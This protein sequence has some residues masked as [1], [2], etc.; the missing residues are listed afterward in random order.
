MGFLYLV[1]VTNLAAAETSRPFRF[2]VFTTDNGLP[3][4]SVRGITQTPDGYLWFTT[5]DG[6]VRFDGVKFTVFDKSNTP[7]IGSNRFML[8]ESAPDGT[9]FAGTEDGGLTVYRDGRFRTLTTADGLPSN[10]MA[11]FRRDRTGETVFL[12]GGGNFYLRGDRVVPADDPDVVANRFTFYTPTGNFWT[13]RDGLVRETKPDGR[14]IDYPLAIRLF[15]EKLTGLEHLEDRAGNLWFG[16]LTGVY[17]LKDGNIRKLTAADGVPENAL[18]R[19][20]V[21]DDEGAIWFASGLGSTRYVGLVRY[22][23]GRFSTFGTEAGLSNLTINEIFKDREGTIWVST[24]KGLNHLRKKMIESLSVADGLVHT[25]V[26]PLLETRA[27]DVYVG[28]T[29]GLSIYRDGKFTTPDLRNKLGDLISATALYEDAKGRIWIGAIGDLHILENGRLRQIAELYRTN[30]WA[31]T[32]DRA[33]NVWVGSGNGLFEFRDDRLVA[34]YTTADGLPD[35]DVK[36]ILERRDGTLWVGTYNGAARLENGR[37]AALT[38][39]DGLPGNRV[40]TLY[41]DARGTLWIGTYDSGLARLKDGRITGYT[42]ENGLFNNGVFAILE[43][44]KNNFW[45]SSNKGIYRVGRQELD[46]F[47]DGRIAKVNAVGY[48]KRDGMLNAEANGGRQ[49]AGVKTRDGRL[50]FPTQD[51]VAII[52]PTKITINDK[53]PAVGIESVLVDHAPA[54]LGREIVIDA[55]KNN[56]EIA[57]TGITFI[58]PEQVR[59]RYRLEGLNDDWIELDTRRSVYFPFLPAGEYT[60]HVTATNSDGVRNDDGARLRIRVEAPFWQHTWFK[61]LGAVAAVLIV[62]WIF[63]RRELVLRRREQLQQEFSRRLIELQEQ[64]RKRIASELHDSIG[65]NL[66]AIKNWALFGLNSTKPENPA[67][68]F[69]NEVSETSSLALAE[70][71]EIAHNLRPYQLERLGLTSTLEHMLKNVKASAPIRFAVEIE[72]VDGALSGESEIVFYR[73]VQETVNNVIKHSRA[74]NAEISIRR[75]AGEL[76]FVCRDDGRGFDVEAARN[77]PARGLGLDGVAERLKILGGDCLIESQ[78]GKG[79]TVTVTVRTVE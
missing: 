28:T 77:S 6:L 71:R 25:E 76:I 23:D 35:N 72:N 64:E 18:L 21:E 14:T 32:G 65:Q 16:D 33:G 45:I 38:T 7:G 3:Q 55:N 5:F 10:E 66:L 2:D 50:W 61:L 11:F 39:A 53:R 4:N 58:A 46:D 51:G 63:R 69:L 41:E 30:V 9:L 54:D 79:T 73:V 44:G 37:F 34:R 62:F 67:R 13:Y 48:D 59:F 70:V 43:D 52:D 31:V 36:T 20:L 8:L 27:G 78:P 57:F 75:D 68:E 42:I 56:L 12:T 60:F 15:N 29:K 1:F 19:P 40:R 74:A 22:F 47:A 26:Y 49:P 17:I 24:D